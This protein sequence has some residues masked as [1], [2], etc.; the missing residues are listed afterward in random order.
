[1]ILDLDNTKAYHLYMFLD[2]DEKPLYIGI[3]KNLNRRIE[4]QHFKSLNG[5]LSQEC[6]DETYSILYH[7]AFSEEDMKLKE[8]YLIN[9][10]NPKY[11]KKMNKQNRFSF[12]IDIDWKLYNVDVENLIEVTRNKRNI[13]K[14][15]LSESIFKES[16]NTNTAQPNDDIKL[17]KKLST[18]I[19][20]NKLR[21]E[22][23]REYDEFYNIHF[24]FTEDELT[25]ENIN[26]ED[27]CNGFETLKLPLLIR[28]KSYTDKKGKLRNQM[29]YKKFFTSVMIFYCEKTK[30]NFNMD[31]FFY[32]L[33]LKNDFCN[34][35]MVSENILF[36][37]EKEIAKVNDK[38]KLDYRYLKKE[39]VNLDI[40]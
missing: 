31:I 17:L 5:N 18:F 10:L 39:F 7:I 40:G 14:S 27:I 22:E 28:E 1:M 34:I 19:K 9:T 25:R 20:N 13:I 26:C 8:R 6:I 15:K 16:Y 37:I 38:I 32:D 36:L 29:I 35:E 21:L 30:V 12:T 33:L 23:K 4:A 2:K 24:S 3:S 11:N